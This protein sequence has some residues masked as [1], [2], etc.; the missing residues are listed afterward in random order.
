[1]Q[2][3]D[4]TPN[5]HVKRYTK[6]TMTNHATAGI[7]GIC[8]D[9]DGTLASYTHDFALYLDGL[10]TDLQLMQCDLNKFTS[11]LSHELKQTGALTLQ[12][13]L[14][15]T[16]I[17]LEQ[18]LPDDLNTITQNALT[19]YAQHV[20]LKKHATR[21]LE[22]CASRWPL[23]LISN[24]PVDMQRAALTQTGIEGFFKDVI[25]SGDPDVAA[26][27]PD[28][29]PFTLACDALGLPAKHVLMIGDSFL[30]DIVG[31][32]QHGMQALL[33]SNDVNEADAGVPVVPDLK[34]LLSYLQATP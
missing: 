15:K 33:I 14:T 6:R 28:A 32:Q 9:F 3:R 10:R 21:T 23:V 34:T 18:R 22:F 13:A 12:S 25:I 5:T 17:T 26:R 7:Q 16:L 29:R 30:A 11:I 1:M 27:K 8:F 20:H 4:T 19:Q 31:A 24:G 2:I